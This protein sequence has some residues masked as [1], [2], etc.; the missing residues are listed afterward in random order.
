MHPHKRPC[1]DAGGGSHPPRGEARG[2]PALPAP[3][4]W[5]WISISRTVKKQLLLFNPAAWVWQPMRDNTGRNQGEQL[6]FW[7]RE[8][9]RRA[10]AGGDSS[11]SHRKTTA[12]RLAVMEKCGEPRSQEVEPKTPGDGHRWLRA[13]NTSKGWSLGPRSGW[14]VTHR[15]QR[16]REGETV[17]E[18][19]FSLNFSTL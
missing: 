10:S 2:Q 11:S 3:W 17:A 1:E 18:A 15:L 9:F 6:S 13:G 4:P 8:G 16:P 5:I 12:A 19:R 14:Q 7:G